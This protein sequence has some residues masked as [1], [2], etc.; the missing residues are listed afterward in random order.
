M[1][2]YRDATAHLKR[3]SKRTREKV[4]H[5]YSKL[6]RITSVTS[7]KGVYLAA[8]EGNYFLAAHETQAMVS[9][10][11]FFKYP[12]DPAQVARLRHGIQISS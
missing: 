9:H 5:I 3:E 1:T 6:Q 10:P 7:K 4:E 11:L 2:S 8:R 12:T